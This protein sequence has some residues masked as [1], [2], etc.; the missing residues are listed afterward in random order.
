M[1]L[2]IFAYRYQVS[3]YNIGFRHGSILN[4]LII[5]FSVRN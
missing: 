3:R 2:F 1:K 4:F 5:I